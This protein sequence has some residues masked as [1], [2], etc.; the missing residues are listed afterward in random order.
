MGRA[1][2]AGVGLVVLGVAGIVVAVVADLGRWPYYG[3]A[4]AVVVGLGLLLAGALRRRTLLVPAVTAVGVLVGGGALRGLNGF[5][6]DHAA[7]PER[8]E[9]YDFTGDAGR[10]GDAW[11]TAGS[12][13]RHRDGRG[14]LDHVGRRRGS[15]HGRGRRSR[16]ADGHGGRQLRA[17]GR[18]TGR[19]AG[20]P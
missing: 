11:F 2:V 19:T 5:P 20:V 7:W 15:L 9:G 14:P 6:E 16:R 12:R 17:H 13:L 1:G 10:L 18:A 3:G 4:A 8:A